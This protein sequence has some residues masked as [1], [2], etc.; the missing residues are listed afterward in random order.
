MLSV[1]KLQIGGGNVNTYWQLLPMRADVL[2]SMVNNR[3]LLLAAL[4]YMSIHFSIVPANMYCYVYREFCC[5]WEKESRSNP[6]RIAS[7]NV[8]NTNT[9][10]VEMRIEFGCMYHRWT[11]Q[12]S[13]MQGE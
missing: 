6:Y 4:T 1:H 12:V 7:C 2:M 8:R 13:L 9:V 10:Y 3:L 5:V 11:E